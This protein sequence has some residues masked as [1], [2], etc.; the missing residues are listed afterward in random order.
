MLVIL[1]SKIVVW[2]SLWNE[3]TERSPLREDV[4]S[5]ELVGALRSGGIRGSRE[6]LLLG[7][8]FEQSDSKVLTTLSW[9]R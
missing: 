7:K 1:T 6:I 9:R 4:A 5:F 2:P 3:L 8:A